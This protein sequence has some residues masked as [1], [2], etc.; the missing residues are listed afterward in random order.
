MRTSIRRSRR[1]GAFVAV[2]ALTTG[3]LAGCANDS[4]DGS[5]NADGGNGSGKG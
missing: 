1:L 2:A 5:S 3:L 4:D